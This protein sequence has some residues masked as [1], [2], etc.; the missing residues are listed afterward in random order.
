VGNLHRRLIAF[1]L[2][3]TLVDSRQDLADSANALIVE[4][5][6]LPLPVDAITAMVGEGA[7]VL[8][9]RALVA[10]GL[11]DPG[12][13]LARF[14]SLYDDRL[15]EHTELYP[16]I[17]DL[18]I[19]AR[20]AATV[21]VL[22]NKPRGPSERILSGL[23]IRDLIDHVVGGDGPYPRKPDATGLLALM[24]EAGADARSTLLVGDS[25]VD[26]ETAQRAGAFCCLVTYGF[27]RAI[28]LPTAREWVADD[29]VA[30]ADVMNQFVVRSN[31]QVDG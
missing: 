2:D 24:G 21:A 10:A 29:A 1:D 17:S 25:P 23:G 7:A 16:G 9:Q 22:T 3:G 30:V 15:L 4:L 14:L 18:L 13:A 28:G 19:A 12:S 20:G 6:G 31:P 27:G 8:V 26:R 5:G 11:T